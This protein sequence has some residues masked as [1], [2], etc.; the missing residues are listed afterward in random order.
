MW[1]RDYL[2]QNQPNQNPKGNKPTRTE[3]VEMKEM[4]RLMMESNQQMKE[5]L[6]NKIGDTSKKMEEKMEENRKKMEEK[7][8]ENSKKAEE[9]SKKMEEKNGRK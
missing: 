8:E 6:G 4:F 9:N 5:E 7:M 2:Q 1:N 3:N